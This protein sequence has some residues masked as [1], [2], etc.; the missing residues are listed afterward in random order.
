MFILTKVINQARLASRFAGQRVSERFVLPRR[1]IPPVR[2]AFVAVLAAG[3]LAFAVELIARGSIRET[4]GFFG[5]TWRPWWTTVLLFALLLAGLDA[6]L[7]RAHHAVTIIAPLLLL[8]AWLCRQKTIY[9]GDPLYPT[10]FFYARQVYEL[11]PLLARERPG[12]VVMAG[13]GIVGVAL[14]IG[15][16]WWFG[17]RRFPVLPWRRRVVRVLVA[18]PALGVMGLLMDY[19]SYSKMRDEL[20]IVPMMWNQKENYS[21]NGFA[22]AFALNLPMAKIAAPA[23]YSEA[24]VHEI[25]E[26]IQ[27]SVTQ[28]GGG[29]GGGGGGGGGVAEGMSAPVEPA[30]SQSDL[31]D[32]IVVMNESFWDASRLPGVTLTPDP[33]P[34][35]RG[36]LSGH[37]FSPEFGGMTSNVEFEALTGF[38]NAFLPYGSIP[39]Q[40]YIRG[41]L[42]SL[43]SFLKQKGY[44]TYALHP[45]F[46]WFW[47]RK[48]VYAAF[49]FEEFLSGQTLPAAALEKR[50]PLV[51]DAAVSEEII[52]RAEASQAGGAPLFLFAV[53]LQNHGPYEAGRYPDATIRVE[54]DLTASSA[55]D[56][57]KPAA[58]LAEINEETRDSIASYAEGT[59]DGDRGLARLV[60]W[61]RGRK[62]ETILVFFGDHLPPLGPVYVNTGFMPDRVAR[63]SGPPEAMVAQHETPLVVWSNRGGAVEDVGTISPALLP[64]H[65]LTAARI[66]H[67]YYTGFLGEVRRHYRVLDRN[68]RIG[69]EGTP[70]AGPLQAAGE[71][72]LLG[73]YRRL[74]YDM[75]F[76]KRYAARI[77]SPES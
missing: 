14:T 73:D 42:P 31:P 66:T 16:V 35:V 59:A 64:F 41:S 43:A 11:L 65:V 37:V 20:R 15:W 44:A 57:N 52:R 27:T 67:P 68:L 21:H 8:T 25:A 74:Q 23:G 18:L 19:S 70:M 38:S 50:G 30:S 45:Y 33:I 13:V 61:A 63:R 34:T 53:T 55:H 76:G 54:V 62:R 4:L 69:A 7:G 5:S 10:D 48:S 47:N 51:S 22:L 75:M 46:D 40:Q 39:Y 2:S 71:D 72:P 28:E 60:E 17:R 36:L 9:L 24:A 6:L 77:F 58:S 29:R 49:G 12:A 32:I 1:V 56:S 26:R 3:V